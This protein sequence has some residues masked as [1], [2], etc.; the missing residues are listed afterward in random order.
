MNYDDLATSLISLHVLAVVS[1]F[2]ENYLQEG[3]SDYEEPS[4][5]EIFLALAHITSL[6]LAIYILWG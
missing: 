5:A 1:Y 2:L 3:G 6:I 4:F